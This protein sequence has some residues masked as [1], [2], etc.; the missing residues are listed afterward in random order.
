MSEEPEPCLPIIS[1]LTGSLHELSS[2]CERLSDNWPNFK[3]VAPSHPFTETDY[4]SDEMGQPLF[5]WWGI[6]KTLDDPSN[7]IEWKKICSR[8]EDSERDEQGNR[9]VNIDP[10]YINFGLVVLGSSKHFH[11][12]IYLGEGVYADPVLEYKDGTFKSFSWS[13]P[14]FKDTRYYEIL[15][16]FRRTY[17]TLRS[18]SS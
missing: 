10:G 16:D 13:F 3:L 17:S 7:L 14:D 9:T 2:G 18:K 8:I 4:Y 15:S 11:Q 5:R 6:R 1:I 12:K